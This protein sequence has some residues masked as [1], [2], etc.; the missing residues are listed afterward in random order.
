MTRAMQARIE[1]L[2]QR[3]WS[4]GPDERLLQ[5]YQAAHR[6]LEAA[7]AAGGPDR[8][9]AFIVFLPVAD[10]PRHLRACLSSLLELCRRFEYGGFRQGRYPKVRV[11]IA[12]DS[13]HPAAIRDHRQW[14]AEFTAHG[15]ETL[16]WGQAEQIAAL[17]RLPAAERERLFGPLNEAAFFHKGSSNMRNLAYLQLQAMAAEMDG[18][19]LFWSI[20]SDQE[21]RIKTPTPQGEQDLFAIPFLHQFDRLFRATDAVLITGKVVGDPPVSP[22]VMTNRFL[23]D[24]NA[25]LRH[26]A[27][28]D[29]TAACGFHGDA[30]S[31]AET[32]AIYHDMADRF[33]FRPERAAYAYNCPLPGAHPNAAAFGRFAHGLN[34]FFHGEHPTRKSWYRHTGLFEGL[35]PAR[36]VYAGNF[37]CNRQGLHWHTPFAPLKLRMSGPTLGRILQAELGS[38]F[39]SANLPMLHRRT[40]EN[41]GRAE[42]RHGV[43][44]QGGTIDLSDELERQFF[45]DVMLFTIIALCQHG[46]PAKPLGREAIRARLQ[47]TQAELLDNYNQRRQSITE[48]LQTLEAQLAA[49]AAWWN[50]PAATEDGGRQA[51]SAVRAFRTFSENLQRNF[52]PQATGYRQI[53]DPN[54][55]ARRLDAITAAILDYP[56][57]RQTWERLL[58][59]E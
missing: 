11:L 51:R 30:Q 12:D 50:R 43:E 57:S 19:V 35:Q 49:P 54:H 34:A 55:Q 21:F 59:P 31:S 26:A 5:A 25:F 15:L 8:R 13:Q 41:L 58:T 53:N 9:H 38:R 33:G 48:K 2:E 56:A 36:T 37:V 27:A 14:A 32:G 3:L 40:V 17:Q 20:D 42:L 18:P 46:Y 28:A 1:E 7:I 45:G 44:H 10:R 22:A 23:D 47:A 4:E 24:V 29:P 16:H 39:R 52:G 6:Q